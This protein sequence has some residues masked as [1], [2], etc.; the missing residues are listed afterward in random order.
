M[1]NS[2]SSFPSGVTGAGLL[3]LRLS[4]GSQLA[5]EA[6]AIVWRPNVGGPGPLLLGISLLVCGL[7]VV[8]G[9]RTRV[10]QTM[11]AAILVGVMSYRLLMVQDPMSVE[12][13][14]IWGLELAIAV[15]L[16]LLGPGWYSIDARLFGRREIVFEARA[17][18]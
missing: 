9:L 6:V 16:V 18:R 17:N 15:S 3:V 5:T 7:F 8:T 10:V 2:S 1:T 4:L 13:W 14:Q 12:R 11:V